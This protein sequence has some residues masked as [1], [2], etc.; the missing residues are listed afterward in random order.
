VERDSALIYTS[1]TPTQREDLWVGSIQDKVNFVWSV[2][3]KILRDDFKR[4]KSPDVIP[5]FTVL[6]RMDSVLEPT[7]DKV[8]D[9]YESLKHRLDNLHGPLARVSGHF[10]YTVSPFTFFRLLPRRKGG[11][12]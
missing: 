3:D 1:S 6:R 9:R 10:F 5:L 12:A 7:K 4:S 2:A 8:L 11:L